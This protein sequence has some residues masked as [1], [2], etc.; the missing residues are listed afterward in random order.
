[1]DPVSDPLLLRKSGSA[2]YRTWTSGSVAKNSDHYTT[3]AVSHTHYIY[4]TY[5]KCFRRVMPSFNLSWLLNDAA[6]I[7]TPCHIICRMVNEYEIFCG[8]QIGKGSLSQGTDWHS[9]YSGWLLDG[10]T[11]GWSSRAGR[12]KN[13]HLSTT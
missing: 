2:G 10:R 5:L 1:V 4:D 13:V 8:S 12:V 9:R 3:E 7:K 6:N 11:R